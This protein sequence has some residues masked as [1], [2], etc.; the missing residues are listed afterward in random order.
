MMQ[1]LIQTSQPQV[2]GS[3]NKLFAPWLRPVEQVLVSLAAW[4]IVP[5]CPVQ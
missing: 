5:V 2:D 4:V 1:T 3:P